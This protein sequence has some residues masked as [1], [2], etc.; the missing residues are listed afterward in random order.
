MAFNQS[1]SVRDVSTEC[2]LRVALGCGPAVGRDG[3]VLA[4]EADDMDVSRL[5]RIANGIP[6]L[7]IGQS[8]Y[9]LAG[10]CRRSWLLWLCR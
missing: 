8:H 6:Q 3:A 10:C 1:V 4:A 9:L 2:R 5:G 7:W